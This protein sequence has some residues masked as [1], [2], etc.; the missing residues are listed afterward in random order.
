MWSSSHNPIALLVSGLIALSLPECHGDDDAA[1]FEARIRPLLIRHCIQCHGPKKQEGGLRLDTRPGWLSGGGRGAAIVP[2]APDKSLLITAVSYS[3][4]D[5]RMPPEKQLSDQEIRDLSDWIR[6]GAFDPRLTDEQPNQRMSLDEAREFWSFQP[7]KRPAVPENQNDQWSRTAIDTFIMAGLQNKGL[8][9]VTD[10]DRRTLIRRA[11]FD[12]TG[13][14][15]TAEEIRAFLNDESPGAFAS[16]VDRLLSSPAYGERWGRHWLDVARYADTAGDGADYPVREAVKYRDWVIRAFNRDQPYDEFVREQIAGDILATQGPRALYAD[17]V[18]ATG[19]LAIGKRY[20]YKASPDYQHLD[21]ADVIDS[22][23]R[24]L[25]GLSIG[26]ARCHDHKYDPISAEDYYALYGI[27]QSTKWAFPGGEE[28]KRP[29]HFPALVPPDEAAGLEQAKKNQL[30]K[31]DSQLMALS[32]EKSALDPATRGGGPDLDIEAQKSGERPG[33]PWVCSGPIEVTPN[34]QSPF[35]HVHPAGKQG[36]RL[37]SGQPTDGLRYVFSNGLRATPGKKMHFTVDFRP[38]AGATEEGAFRFYLGRGVVQSLAIECSAT[39]TEFALR[40]GTQW[41]TIRRLT[42]GTWYTLQVTI[43][44]HSKTYS[45]VVGTRD[46]LTA[47]T[48]RKTGPSWDGIADCFICDAFGH[49][50]GAACARDIDNLGLQP[51]PFASVDSPPVQP[52]TVAPDARAR[53]AE[54]QAQVEKLKA[55]RKKLAVADVYPV[56]YAVSEDKPVNARL[57]HRGEPH[58]TGNEVARRNLHVLGGDSLRDPHVSGRLDLANWLTR[59]TNPLTARVF[60]NRVWQWHF[61]RGIVAT[62][63]DFGSRGTP[64][65]HPELL[66]WLTVQF[67]ESGWS[68]KSLHR[69]I[70]SSRTWQLSSAAH[71]GNLVTD[72][73]NNWY[74]RHSRRALDAESVRDGMLAVSGNLERTIPG[75]HPFPPVNTWGFTIHHPFHAVYD[76]NHRSVYLMVQRNRRHPY[77]ALFDAADPNQSVAG[78]QPTTTPTQALYLMNSPFVHEQARG[79][80]SRILQVR[81][82]DETRLRWAFETAHGRIPDQVVLDDA[83]AFVEIYRSRLENDEQSDANQT[84]AWSALARVLLTGNGFLFVD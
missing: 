43:D 36:V 55:Q 3:D 18:T 57:Q 73:S 25:M 39:S 2:D 12:L 47:F 33:D 65:T 30:A 38:V 1:F 81:G 80:A 4:S 58:R 76:S 13:M 71:A 32:Q 62:A 59:P 40:N 22:V 31:V 7:L 66:D 67:I 26:C 79:F 11:T 74:W 51:E 56:A 48:D 54:I 16:L 20:G 75:P 70:L 84:A 10:A 28:Q 77:L 83:Q 23:G 9:P 46:D 64:P 49:I 14:P 50:P 44:P 52:S 41:E 19:F 5:L 42:P 45:G 8:T 37:G 53:L 21:F 6:N 68:V 34:A 17:R 24:S 78:R 69:L 63:S 35:T 82:N 72:P 15:P 61:G 60:V 27:F 29:A